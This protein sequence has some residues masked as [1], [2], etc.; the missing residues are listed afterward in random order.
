MFLTLL[1]HPEPFFFFE[2]TQNDFNL[3]EIVNV[4]NLLGKRHLTKQDY[5][6]HEKK[7]YQSVASD[8]AVPPLS[9][10]DLQVMKG[11]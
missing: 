3:S 10:L 7:K 4:S 6:R 9:E 2:L 11:K 8:S 5:K 1:L